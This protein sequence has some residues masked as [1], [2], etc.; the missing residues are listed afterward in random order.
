MLEVTAGGRASRQ[1]S[2]ARA[3]SRASID[4]GRDMRRQPPV[5]KAKLKLPVVDGYGVAVVWIIRLAPQLELRAC[6]Q[7]GDDV[8]APFKRDARELRVKTRRVADRCVVVV[9]ILVALGE[10]ALD[11]GIRRSLRLPR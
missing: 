6:S 11:K 10:E 8:L 7:P 2:D 1:R 5:E 9:Q 3:V 4:Q